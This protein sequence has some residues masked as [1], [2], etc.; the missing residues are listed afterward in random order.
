[1]GKGEFLN[2]CPKCMVPSDW[3]GA[4]NLIEP[5]WNRLPRFFVYPMALRPMGLILGM[6]LAGF[7]F[8]GPGF[9]SLIVHIAIWGIILKYSYAALKATARG[10]LVPPK[11]DSKTISDDFH[12]VF[13]QLGIFIAIFFGFIFVQQFA[14]I[15]FAALFLIVAILSVPAMI[16]IFVTT[17][18]LMHAINPVIFI[19]LALRIGWGYLLMYFF[20]VLLLFAPAALAQFAFKILPPELTIFLLSLGKNYYTIISYHL[21]GY[22]ILQY[23]QSIGYKIDF[24]DFRDSPD[25]GKGAKEE[26]GSELLSKINFMFKE[27]RHDE[28]LVLIKEEEKKNGI[29]DPDISECYFKLL[30]M[31]NRIDEMLVHGKRHLEIMVQRNEKQKACEAYKQCIAKDP[32]FAPDAYVLFKLGGWLNEFGKSREAIGTYN[33]LVKTFPDAPLVPKTLFRA[34]QIYNDRLM[35][36]AKAETILKAIIKN[37]PDHELIP[38]I[39][40]Y[41]VQIKS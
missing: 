20:L 39:Q 1:M 6:S 31:M 35:N 25:Y 41:L 18:S 17:E 15:F 23:H 13:K 30:A 33:R 24:E 40:N 16:I 10:D 21:M 28:A 34:A 4:A 22:V 27:G 11:I 26:K 5:F 12:Q 14:G 19:Q 3:I 2:L 29:D 7:I 36:P 32:R 37:Y 9:I 38:S 8:R